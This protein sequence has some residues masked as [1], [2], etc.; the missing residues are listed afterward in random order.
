MSI[1]QKIA[2]GRTITGM[3][4]GRLANEYCLLHHAPAFVGGGPHRL[5]LPSG[6]VWVVPILLTSPGYGVVGEVG[7]IA[8]DAHEGKVVSAPA[9]AEVFAAAKRLDKEKRHELEAAF[10]RVRGNRCLNQSCLR[11]AFV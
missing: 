4:A 11:L 5:S 3:K 7:M 9:R 8:L 10:H 1:R 2:R 6:D